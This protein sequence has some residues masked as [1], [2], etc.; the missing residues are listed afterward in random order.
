MDRKI[1]KM[2]LK[3]SKKYKKIKINK[4]NLVNRIF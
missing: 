1:K 2:D 4:K 3:M